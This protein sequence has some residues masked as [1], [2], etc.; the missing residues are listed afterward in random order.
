M[1]VCLAAAGAVVFGGVRVAA[2][3]IQDRPWH[4]GVGSDMAK[5]AALGLTLGLAAP[6][7]ATTSTAGATNG[8]AIA[9]GAQRAFDS[10]SSFKRAMGSAGDKAD[11]HHVVEQTPGNVSKFGARAIHNTQNLVRVARDVHQKISGYYS[12]K[13]AF[14]GGQTVRQ[15]LSGQSFEKQVDFGRQAMEKFGASQ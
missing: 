12:S 14:T 10:F 1:N 4:D 3:L 8:A 15:W 5:G 9:T 13:Q 2:N 7:L 6:A 11:W